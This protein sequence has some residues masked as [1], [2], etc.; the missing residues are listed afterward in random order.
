MPY[1]QLE[2]TRLRFFGGTVNIWGGRCAPL[3]DIDYQRRPWV[4]HSG[5][6]ITAEDLTPY[7]ERVQ[8]DPRHGPGLRRRLYF[9]LKHQIPANQSGRRLWH[10]YRGVRQWTHR[11]FRTSDKRIRVALGVCGL[12]VMVRAEQ[13]PNPASR[14]VLSAQRDALDVRRLNLDWRLSE[15]DKRT[16][17]VLADLLGKKNLTAW[18]SAT[19]AP[20]NGLQRMP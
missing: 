19:C 3:D 7:F 12:S 15:I 9:H 14:V 6:P 11:Y 20:V 4:S 18:G 2:E 8:R 16:V 17:A 5:W 13:A 1:Y 10:A